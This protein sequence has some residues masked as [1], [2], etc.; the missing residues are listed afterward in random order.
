MA[1]PKVIALTDADEVVRF[2]DEQDLIRQMVGANIPGSE[3][4]KYAFRKLA[5]AVHEMRRLQT[6]YFKATHGSDSKKALLR[7]SKEAEAKVDNILKRA[8]DIDLL[9]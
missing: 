4:A 5:E 6:D 3:P 9:P 7:M 2:F 1:K 8:K